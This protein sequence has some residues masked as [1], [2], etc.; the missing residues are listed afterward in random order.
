[1]RERKAV[2]VGNLRL[3]YVLVKD[4]NSIILVL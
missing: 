3:F 4:L 1:M 2:Q